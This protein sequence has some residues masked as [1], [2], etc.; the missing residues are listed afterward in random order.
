VVIGIG[1]IGT[2][3][4]SRR[5]CAA[6]AELRDQAEMVAVCELFEERARGA[7]EPF[8]A[9]VYTGAHEVFPR[10]RLDAGSI[11]VPP[12]AHVHQ[13]LTCAAKGIHCFVEKPL[14]LHLPQA[15]QIARASRAARIYR[16]TEQQLQIDDAAGRRT[17]AYDENAGLLRAIA[18]GDRSGILSDYE[19]ALQTQRVVRAADRSAETGRP[20]RPGDG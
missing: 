15:E 18:V 12:D 6:L 16:L 5:R 2:G 8:G 10:E 1:F 17:V 20:L 4:I 11:C 9:H 14:P 3:T 7:A 13:E 19:D